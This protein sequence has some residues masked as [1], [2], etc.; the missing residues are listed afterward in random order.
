MLIII[1]N[2]QLLFLLLLLLLFSCCRLE[3]LLLGLLV[4]RP[5]I[6]CL[7]Q[8]YYDSLFY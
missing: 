5:S 6:S 3:F 7:L 8:V 2:K 1:T 4:L